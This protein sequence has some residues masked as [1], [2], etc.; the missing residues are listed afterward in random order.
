MDIML[1]LLRALYLHSR[2]ASS[3]PSTTLTMSN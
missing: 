1:D 2:A 3:P